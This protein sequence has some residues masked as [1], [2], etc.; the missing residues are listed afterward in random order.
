MFRQTLKDLRDPAN[1]EKIR[2]RNNGFDYDAWSK[3]YKDATVD[4]TD[5]EKKLAACGE[6]IEVDLDYVGITAVED[7]LQ[8]GVPETIE[9]LR[10]AGLRVWVLTGDKV[11]TAI[12]IGY[13]CKLLEKEGMELLRLVGL[14]DVAKVRTNL[15]NALK[16]IETEHAKGLHVGMA[17]DGFSI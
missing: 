2:E 12:D 17:M 10:H 16:V 5:R 4:L 8:E 7:L 9:L 3:K 1:N 14:T 15:E 11:E 6:E 13:S